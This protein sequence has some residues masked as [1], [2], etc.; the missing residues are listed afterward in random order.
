[1]RGVYGGFGVKC[2][3][4]S[5]LIENNYVDHFIVGV[6][7]EAAANPII[8][9]NSLACADS[10]GVNNRDPSVT[11]D[12][13]NNWWGGE[14]GPEHNDNEGGQG[15]PVSDYVIFSPWLTGYPNRPP[16]PFHLLSP[17]NGAVLD[18]VRLE[19]M[20]RLDWE[21]SRDPDCDEV[22]VYTLYVA[23]DEVFT[24][25]LIMGGIPES[26][27]VLPVTLFGHHSFFQGGKTY[28]WK[29][30]V[31][32]GTAADSTWS[33][34]LDWSFDIHPAVDAPDVR[35]GLPTRWRLARSAPNPFSSSTMI[36]YDVPVEGPVRITVHDVTGRLVRRV[37]EGRTRA[38]Y[39][40]VR[41]D[42]RDSNGKRVA[43]GIYF[44]R[45]QADGYTNS[46][47]MVLLK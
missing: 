22:L 9:N 31:T 23:D 12:A 44:Y 13:T 21:D 34:E 20:R 17:L 40:N 18:T 41:W 2:A 37:A 28:Y 4:S 19:T 24:D 42:G 6:D 15:S 45:M 29:V 14:S 25:P 43:A 33:L 8:T 3:A 38:G 46:R 10:F 39:H 27:Y 35:P 11:I 30:R 26:E 36:H 47:K 16:L 32:D 1:L 5:P 7:T